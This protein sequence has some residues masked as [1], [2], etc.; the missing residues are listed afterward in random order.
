MID[1]VK[2]GFLILVLWIIEQLC[3]LLKLKEESSFNE[4]DTTLNQNNIKK[5]FLIERYKR[6]VLLIMQIVND[7]LSQCV[8]L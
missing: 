7:K 8:T 3:V 2:Q 4:V 6:I 1:I 5:Y